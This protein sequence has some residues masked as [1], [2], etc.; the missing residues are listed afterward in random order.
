MKKTVFAALAILATTAVLANP[1]EG[2]SRAGS[3]TVGL[4]YD[5][6]N[7]NGDSVLRNSQEAA[8]T[9][10]QDTNIGTFDAALIIRNVDS[11]RF[12]G[13]LSQGYE[14]GYSKKFQL[15]DTIGLKGRLGYGQIN[16]IQKKSIGSL[17]GN[18]GNGDYASAT[19]E[20]SYKFTDTVVGFTGF[21]HRNGLQSVVTDQNRA[22]IG[23]DFK[24]TPNIGLRGAFVHD[25]Q[26]DRSSNGV[27]TH[28]TYQF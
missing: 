27:A 18:T 11:A 7:P 1:L 6:T 14:I 8:L 28:L 26:N 23:A 5:Y 12:G 21:R 9:I 20:A 13:D 2:I 15:T 22:Y 3:P 19:V 17:T 16:G 25:R 4:S 10:S 24:L